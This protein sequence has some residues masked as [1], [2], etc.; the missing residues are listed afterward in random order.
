MP[1]QPK[2]LDELF[3]DGLRN[4]YFGEKKILRRVK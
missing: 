4:I 3:Y 1:K 2:M